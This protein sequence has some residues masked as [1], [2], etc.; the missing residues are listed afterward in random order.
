MTDP[1]QMPETFGTAND[2]P[3]VREMRTQLC[4][5]QAL[6][7]LMKPDQRAELKGLESQIDE[8]VGVVD[9]FYQLLGTRN[10]IYHDDLSL[11]SMREVIAAEDSE[12]AE[13]K[14]IRYYQDRDAL[15]FPLLRLGRLAAIR[16]RLDLVEKAY[17]DYQAGR[18][19]A[20]VLLLIAVMDGT[21]ND[22]DQSQRR[23]LHARDAEELIA[24]DSVT[25][26]HLGLKHAHATFTKSFRK[27]TT[28]EVTELYRN[29]IVHGMVVNF[30][31]VVVATK[32]LNRLFAV[33]DWAINLLEQAE[34]KPQEPSPSEMLAKRAETRRDMKIIEAFS[35]SG[36]AVTDAL[37][38]GDEVVRVVRDFLE[39]WQ[40][41][42]FGAVS[43]TFMRFGSASGTAGRLAGEAKNLY[44]DFHLTDYLIKHVRHT[45]ACLTLVDADLTV[46]GARYSVEL[47][48]VHS[49]DQ[50]EVTVPGH[51]GAW[52]LAPY[53]PTSF[54][55]QEKP[56]TEPLKQPAEVQPES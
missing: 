43:N 2:L 27:T 18:Y 19:Y 47:R 46:N 21:V 13:Q 56:V 33:T 38:D 37:N 12:A 51:A 1:K 50:G 24:W 23:G 52:R 26:H 25:A 5:F 36:Q 35:P 4:G 45:A 8:I 14:L 11:P 48:W 39:A 17:E 6:R 41:K 31:N 20:A 44:R 15:K 22:F 3:T 29:G 7:F 40:R 55:D 16:P 9:G 32:A 34:P 53:G 10:W 42:N 30:D 28:D 54:M 49:N